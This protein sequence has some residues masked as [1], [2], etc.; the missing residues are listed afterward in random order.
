M[1]EVSRIV[2]HG[3]K[4]HSILGAGIDALLE[5]VQCVTNTW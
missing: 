1:T 5:A 2:A 4:G 3:L